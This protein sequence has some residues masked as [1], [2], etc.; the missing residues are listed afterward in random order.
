[1]FQKDF[2]PILINLPNDLDYADI[3]FIHDVHYGSE[4]FDEKKWKNL[5]NKIAEESKAFVCWVGDL[6]ENAIPNSKSDMFSQ[7]H[8]PAEQKEWVTEQLRDLSE[9]TLAVV[10]GNHEKNRTTKASGLYPLYDCCLIAGI[11]DKYRDTIAFIDIGI[12]STRKNRQKQIHYFGQI[13]HKAKDIKNYH[14]SDFTDGID[15]FASGH[16]HETKDK[17]RAKMVFDKHNKVIYKRNIECLN[18]GSFCEFGGYG[19]ENAYRPQSDKMYKL[20]LYG[21]KRG[22][23]T[24]GF[25]I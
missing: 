21:D 25:Y 8:T 11:G 2:T 19:S 13:Q 18:C 4:L 15:F 17:P 1:L 20:R 6:M 5:K 12:G 9:K 16:D 10:A 7:K 3:Y 24:A 23:E 22:M 14:S